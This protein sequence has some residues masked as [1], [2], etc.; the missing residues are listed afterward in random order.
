VGLGG[1]LTAAFIA[2]G[3]LSGSIPFGV[4]LTR[5]F[6]GKDV[7]AGGSGNIGATNVARVAGKKL[8]AIVLVLDALKGA[9]PVML[10]MRE[11]PGAYLVHAGVGLAA[12]LGH[13]FPIWLKLKGGKGVAT[14]AGVLAVLVPAAAAAG[15]L[16]FVVLVALF[17]VASIGSLAGGLTAVGVSFFLGRPIEYP[18]LG[19][20]LM[21][22]MVFTH[23][24][25]IGRLLKR[26]ENQV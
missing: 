20:V 2:L 21:V 4:L 19:V 23:R 6:A 22:L 14:A 10:A 8:G 15:L 3:Y 16:V 13:V 1:G 9:V 24:G 18:L 5:W 17:R 7:R 11:L 12:F 25:N 26:A